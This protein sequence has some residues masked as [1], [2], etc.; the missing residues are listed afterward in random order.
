MVAGVGGS[1]GKAEPKLSFRLL[2]DIPLSC[3]GTVLRSSRN[4]RNGLLRLVEGRR[5]ACLEPWRVLLCEAAL[6]A[7]QSACCYGEGRDFA[8]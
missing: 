7:P 6:W 4:C 1:G 5:I 3:R 8:E 2:Q